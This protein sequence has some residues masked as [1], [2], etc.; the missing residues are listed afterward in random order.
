MMPS[1]PNSAASAPSV[2]SSKS[3]A[4][5]GALGESRV[6]MHVVTEDDQVTFALSNVGFTFDQGAWVYVREQAGK[7]LQ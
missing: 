3:S 6:E 5:A 2:T 4:R 7:A 1:P